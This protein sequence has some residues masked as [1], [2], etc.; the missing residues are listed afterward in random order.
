MDAAFAAMTDR[1]LEGLLTAGRWVA[2]GRLST[3]ED[4]QI[5]AEQW[6]R[7]AKGE[8]FKWWR[9]AGGNLD[10][11]LSLADEVLWDAAIRFESSRGFS[12]GTYLGRA[13]RNAFIS[14]RREP[15]QFADGAEERIPDRE[16]Q[17]GHDKKLSPEILHAL[18][19]LETRERE[20][21]VQCVMRGESVGELAAR[22]RMS[23]AGVRQ[24]IK[25]ELRRLRRVLERP[26]DYSEQRE[27]WEEAG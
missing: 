18:A 12:F 1:Q 14:V 6:E 21:I 11:W 17:D 3:V 23:S 24:I 13:L 4:Q 27:L 25:R 19:V 8:A 15:G 26:G 2:N 10:D 7:F 9:R 22:L 16:H 20:I 5:L